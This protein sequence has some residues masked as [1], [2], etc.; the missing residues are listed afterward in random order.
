MTELRSSGITAVPTFFPPKLLE[1]S[2]AVAATSSLPFAVSPPLF[3]SVMLLSI[4]CPE[5]LPLVL[6]AEA[7]MGVGSKVS[8]RVLG[9]VRGDM[10]SGGEYCISIRLG[11]IVESDL[12]EPKD[13]LDLKDGRLNGGVGSAYKR[14]GEVSGVIKDGDGV[15]VALDPGRSSVLSTIS[16]S[17]SKRVATTS[18]IGVAIEHERGDDSSIAFK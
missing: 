1:S 18:R 5:I 10:Y 7:N 15:D 3:S 16:F 17:R 11:L 2:V 8:S 12:V 13:A 9:E 14:P 4:R 6:T